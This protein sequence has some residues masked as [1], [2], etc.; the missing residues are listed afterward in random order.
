MTRCL[1]AYVL[2]ALLLLQSFGRELLVLNFAVNQAAIT[3]KYCVNKARPRLHCDGKCYLARQLHRAENGHPKAPAS[4]LAAVKF[5]VVAPGSFQ[6]PPLERVSWAAAL[7]YA[8]LAARPDAAA[9][10]GGVFHPPALLG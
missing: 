7:R 10:L 1:L 4:N 9:P 5:E 2:T 6:L 8:P 3:A